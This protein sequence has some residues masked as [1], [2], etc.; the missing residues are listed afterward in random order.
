MTHA[1]EQAIILAKNVTQYQVQD[2]L[3]LHKNI[4]EVRTSNESNENQQR[5]EWVTDLFVLKF[6]SLI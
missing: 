1:L 5:A 2:L 6:Y 3:P 4:F